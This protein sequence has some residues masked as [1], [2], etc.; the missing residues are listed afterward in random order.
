M[1]IRDSY[2]VHHI[3][4][5]DKAI[6]NPWKLQYYCKKGKSAYMADLIDND[7]SKPVSYTHL[8][9]IFLTQSVYSNHRSH[10]E[11]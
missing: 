6:E 11:V 4:G 7:K 9:C 2:M 3:N 10:V 1:C 5:E 8:T